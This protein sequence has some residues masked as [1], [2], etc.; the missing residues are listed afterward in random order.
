MSTSAILPR[1]HI[2][3]VIRK[4]SRIQAGQSTQTPNGSRQHRNCRT[5]VPG[6]RKELLNEARSAE[7]PGG[8]SAARLPEESAFLLLAT[9]LY[10]P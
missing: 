1:V 10:L 4:C 8:L 2:G 9:Y 3:E 6:A 7:R 5:S